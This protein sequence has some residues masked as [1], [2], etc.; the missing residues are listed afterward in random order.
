[1]AR[2]PAP[3][4]DATSLDNGE[5]TQATTTHLGATECPAAS[6]APSVLPGLALAATPT[7]L[8]A[9]GLPGASPVLGDTPT[10]LPPTPMR[11]GRQPAPQKQ[12]PPP[13]AIAAQSELALMLQREREHG[14]GQQQRGQPQQQQQ[15]QQPYQQP[16]LL[17]QQQP[18]Q[19]QG[20]LQQQQPPAPYYD[21]IDYNVFDPRA[22]DNNHRRPVGDEAQAYLYQDFSADMLF[23]VEDLPD[24]DYNAEEMQVNV[25]FVS[26]CSLGTFEHI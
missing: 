17:Q 2:V 26:K 18:Q 1:M 7:S 13:S 3:A 8:A 21:N 19:Q 16:R 15:Q 23:G 6:L 20:Q 11:R 4:G 5:S 25:L 10:F 14:R 12:L 22:Q 9:S 24:L